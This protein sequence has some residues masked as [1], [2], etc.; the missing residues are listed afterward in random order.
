[1]LQVKPLVQARVHQIRRSITRLAIQN[2][3]ILQQIN[4]CAGLKMENLLGKS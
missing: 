2:L 3:L 4:V 1:M